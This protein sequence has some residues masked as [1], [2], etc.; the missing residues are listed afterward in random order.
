MLFKG[1]FNRVVRSHEALMLGLLVGVI[2]GVLLML[3]VNIQVK[4]DN[5]KAPIAQ[6]GAGTDNVASASFS[7]TG[8]IKKV[9]CK[10]KRVF[11]NF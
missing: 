7:Y 8:K 4:S 5:W 10:D 6:C 1:K 3:M 2:A 9:V 11:T